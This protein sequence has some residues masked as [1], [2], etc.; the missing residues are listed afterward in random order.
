MK[1]VVIFGNGQTA[2][3]IHDYFVNDSDY[4]VVAFCVDHKFAKQKHYL[5]KPLVPLSKLKTTYPPQRYLMHIALSYSGINEKRKQKF[6]EIRNMG[7]SFANFISSKS[8]VPKNLIVG[9][10]TVVLENQSIQPFVKIL[11]N[12]MVWSGSVIG[13]HSII[14]S[15]V[16]ITS[17]AN[18]GGNCNIGEKCFLGLNCT[19]GNMV[20]IGKNCFI[21]A[22]SLVTKDLSHNKVCIKSDTEI[23]KLNSKDFKRLTNFK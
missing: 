7:Y 12:V 4:E 1:K 17:G 3:I 19:V 8:N 5:G 16:W 20:K 11:D 13:H 23:F 22:N 18:I 9:K 10:N 15:H 14:K 2:D 21:G 6:I